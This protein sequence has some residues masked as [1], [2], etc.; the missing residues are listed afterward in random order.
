MSVLPRIVSEARWHLSVH[1]CK[2]VSSPPI[3][4]SFQ[5]FFFSD[6]FQN[7]EL[8]R[9]RAE[10]QVLANELKAGA[11]S[12]APVL[13]CDSNIHLQIFLFV[14]CR[15]CLYSTYWLMD[16]FACPEPPALDSSWEETEG[17]PCS[18]PC[19]ARVVPPWMG[20]LPE[21][22]ETDPGAVL[23]FHAWLSGL[24][25]SPFQCWRWFCFR[26]VFVWRVVFS[27]TEVQGVISMT[28]FWRIM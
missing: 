3:S 7:A 20:R 8:C 24:L 5:W 27:V 19:R 13:P 18:A 25:I 12:A 17:F 4:D 21:I 2:S 11:Y 28:G 26:G 6:L 14:T 1:R 23:D 15:A 10:K 9:N 22:E 16:P